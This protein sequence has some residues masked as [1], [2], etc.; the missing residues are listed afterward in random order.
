MGNF[1][2]DLKKHKVFR[3]AALSTAVSWLLIRI[4]DVVLPAFE[5]LQWISQALI[6]ILVL[7]FQLTH[8]C[9]DAIAGSMKYI[10]IAIAVSMMSFSPQ[11]YGR[12]LCRI[13]CE[14]AQ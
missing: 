14:I 3:V 12:G 1:S 11:V 10:Q 7:G 2:Q 8:R 4:S 5:I 9:F 6:L 13:C